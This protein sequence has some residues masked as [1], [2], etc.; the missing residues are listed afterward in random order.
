MSKIPWCWYDHPRQSLASIGPQPYIAKGKARSCTSPC[1]RA[2][3]SCS[4]GIQYID[5]LQSCSFLSRYWL[6]CLIS[7]PTS[8]SHAKPTTLFQRITDNA[9]PTMPTTTSSFSQMRSARLACSSSQQGQNI[10]A[11]VATASLNV[12]ITA[13]GS[14]TVSDG[15]ITIT[16]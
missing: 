7:S 16:F 3:S 15:V 12:T 4:C 2:Q 11:F 14:T 9:C 10:A 13:H 8:L 6:F 1:S 5:C